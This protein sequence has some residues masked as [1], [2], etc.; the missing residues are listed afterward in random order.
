M[1]WKTLLCLALL[2][3]GVQSKGE[4][5]VKIGEVNPITGAIGRYGTT[6]HQG[7]QLAIDQAN[8]A[9]GV[10]GKKISLLTEDN[11]SQA[12]QTST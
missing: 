1:G 9:G 12:G 8:S 10:L 3:A 11:Q 5:V 2:L 7:I 4:E 6:C